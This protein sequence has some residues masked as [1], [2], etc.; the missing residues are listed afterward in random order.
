[1]TVRAIV[2]AAAFIVLT[3]CGE[4]P[5]GPVTFEGDALREHPAIETYRNIR[6]LAADGDIE[7]AAAL[8]DDPAAFINQISGH[9]ERMGED[10]FAK[11]MRYVAENAPFHALRWEQGYSA[12]ILALDENTPSK[13]AVT[14]FK[15]GPNGDPLEIVSRDDNVP[16]ALVRYFYEEKGEPETEVVNCAEPASADAES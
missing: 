5:T 10:A 15:D 14:F 16:C 4:K 8:T 2:G 13:M 3:A 12:L 9:R 6:L 7:G 1:M 11:A